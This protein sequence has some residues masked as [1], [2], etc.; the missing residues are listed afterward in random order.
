MQPYE[1]HLNGKK[2]RRKKEMNK[3]FKRLLSVMLALVMVVGMIPLSAV[4][5]KAATISKGQRIYFDTNGDSEFTKDSAV[6]SVLFKDGENS[7]N[8]TWVLMTKV[9][10]S[11]TLYYADA[12][13]DNVTHLQFRRSSSTNADWNSGTT[14][15]ALQD[16]MNCYKISSWNASSWSNTGAW[17]TYTE[18][19]GGTTDTPADGTKRIYFDTR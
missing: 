5:T 2:E 9:D 16:G 3:V 7:T 1:K 12:D 11:D 14:K 10:G 13:R 17:S 19:G 8:G 18:S 4:P 15:V 6:P